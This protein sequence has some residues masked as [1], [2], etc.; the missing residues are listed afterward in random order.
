[1]AKKTSISSY[2]SKNF[3]SS[4]FTIFLPLFFIGSL[5]FIIKISSLTASIQ[6]SFIEMMQLF[7][8]NLPSILF[9]TLPVSF[10]VAM[11][12]TLLRLSNDNELMALFALG[13]NAKVLLYRFFFIG[14]L[15]S[16]ILLI[17]SL[18][19]MPK[20]KQ[21]FKAFKH[22]KTSQAQVNIN[23]SKLGQKFGDLF[24]YVKSKETDTMK[25]IVIYKKDKIHSD[26]L[27]IAQKANFDNNN[28]LVTLTLTN[29]SGYTFSPNGLKKINYES[30]KVFQNLNSDAF[31][32][33]NIVQYWIKLSLNPKKK[34]K[35]FFFIFASL[36]PLLSLAII[37]SFSIINPRYQKNHAY[38]AL[39]VTTIGLYSSAIILESKGTLLMLFGFSFV[40]LFLG[41]Y[42]YKRLV[43]RFF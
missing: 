24:V 32:Y 40:A 42:L 39:A 16:I 7:G 14:L 18:A 23:P 3:Q 30:M 5:V 37:A 6:I 13:S 36:I 1:M 31:T 43:L 15:F 38:Q 34:S 9:Y 27:F 2:L 22:E 29:G 35:I 10:L 11:V 28:S 8:Y 12:M 21:Q 41:F 4:F 20:T 25:D 33:N 19:L 26:Q 17:L